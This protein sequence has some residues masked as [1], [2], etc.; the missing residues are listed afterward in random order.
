MV[1]FTLELSLLRDEHDTSEATENREESAG[2]TKKG[3]CLK[4]AMKVLL[5]RKEDKWHKGHGIMRVNMK[6]V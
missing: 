2:K 1:Q 4:G 3:T 5:T 6:A